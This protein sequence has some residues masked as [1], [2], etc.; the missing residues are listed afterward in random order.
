[1]RR[2][3]T[4]LMQI[5]LTELSVRLRTNCNPNCEQTKLPTCHDLTILYTK[6]VTYITKRVKSETQTTLFQR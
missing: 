1:M 2:N 3:F 4:Y 5:T 6:L